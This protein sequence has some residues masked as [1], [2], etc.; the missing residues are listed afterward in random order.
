MRK[1]AFLSHHRVFGI[2]EE[3]AHPEKIVPSAMMSAED[4][5]EHHVFASTILIGFHEIDMKFDLRLKPGLL[6]TWGEVGSL[7]RRFF[8]GAAVEWGSFH[9]FTP[10]G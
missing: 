8:K 3:I 4:D 9:Q 7:P 6:T 1:P 2:Q 10:R 5:R